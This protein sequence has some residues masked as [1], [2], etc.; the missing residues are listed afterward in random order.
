MTSQELKNDKQTFISNVDKFVEEY[1]D[2][3]KKIKSLDN[4]FA[5]CDDTLL[6]NEMLNNN[7]TIADN[8]TNIIN[9]VLSEKASIIARIDEE[10]KRLQ[11]QEYELLLKNKELQEEE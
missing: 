3:L 1:Q 2:A 11:E 6:K 9:K 10:I 8:I 4:T 5:N 7:Q